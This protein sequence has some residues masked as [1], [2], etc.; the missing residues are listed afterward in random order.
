MNGSNVI[1]GGFLAK[2]NTRLARQ[3]LNT[4]SSMGNRNLVVELMRSTIVRQ[5]E[6]TNLSNDYDSLVKRAESELNRLDSDT[7]TD[8]REIFL[9]LACANAVNDIV[10]SMPRTKTSNELN[11][12]NGFTMFHSLLISRS[13]EDLVNVSTEIE[14][15]SIRQYLSRLYA[16]Q[17]KH[18]C[19]YN[20]ILALVMISTL[21]DCSAFDQ[22]RLE[23]NPKSDSEFKRTYSYINAVIRIGIGCLFPDLE[24][25]DNFKFI[26]VIESI[27][28]DTKE[29]LNA[30]ARFLLSC[31]D[32]ENDVLEDHE[33]Q[34]I[35]D[36]VTQQSKV[37]LEKAY[38]QYV[39]SN[40]P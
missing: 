14:E 26:G 6:N 34:K 19:R 24:P 15:A 8:V 32:P 40:K 31:E 20:S 22:S 18:C 17:V 16:E 1:D 10:A 30:I 9:Y 27:L 38:Q 29:G 35:R 13:S 21:K 37:I 7:A 28:G 4:V 36:A 39:E 33:S 3:V 25:I 2:K 5:L 12:V 23:Y 11:T